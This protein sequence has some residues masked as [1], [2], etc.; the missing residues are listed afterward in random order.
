M[1]KI[2]KW[3]RLLLMLTHKSNHW[4]VSI[5]WILMLVSR[6]DEKKKKFRFL[7]IKSKIWPLSGFIRMLLEPIIWFSYRNNK[8]CIEKQCLN[9]ILEKKISVTLSI[10]SIYDI[11]RKTL[12]K[13]LWR[14]G[15]FRFKFFMDTEKCL[16][17]QTLRCSQ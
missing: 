2:W 11:G 1:P 9:F 10:P 12:G 4:W 6:I 13:R 8:K 15:W 16:H 5:F 14:Y 17:F 7:P 3:W